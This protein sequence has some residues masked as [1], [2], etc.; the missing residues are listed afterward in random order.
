[1]SHDFLLLQVFSHYA[2]KNCPTAD[3]QL[4]TLLLGDC[5][6]TPD[7]K[8][9]AGP[10]WSLMFEV[11]ESKVKPVGQVGAVAMIPGAAL[12]VIAQRCRAQRCRVG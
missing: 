9:E 4:R 5:S 1:M 7:S 12:A 10:Y 2:P 6:E 8:P 3:T 11:S